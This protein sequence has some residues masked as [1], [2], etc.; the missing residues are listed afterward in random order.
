MHYGTAAYEPSWV[1]LPQPCRT[2]GR[3]CSWPPSPSPDQHQHQH[4]HQQHGNIIISDVMISTIHS[5]SKN[6]WKPSRL[7]SE[8]K[9]TKLKSARS[10]M[11]TEA[12][13]RDKSMCRPGT[14]G[15]T[16]EQTKMPR[17][18]H[19]ASTLPQGSIWPLH[20]RPWWAATPPQNKSDTVPSLTGGRSV[21]GFLITISEK[22]KRSRCYNTIHV[23]TYSYFRTTSAD[24]SRQ[25]RTALSNKLH[26]NTYISYV[27]NP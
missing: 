12:A 14:M 11:C 13:E 18:H 23:H 3:A 21:F 5:D 24:C 17:K 2:E 7:C 19:K 27:D 9:K 25:T 8:R 1:N 15:P 22:V 16:V 6:Y 4:Q 20:R 10:R 26:A